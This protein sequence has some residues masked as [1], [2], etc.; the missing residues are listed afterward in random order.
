MVY[1][2]A[3][4]ILPIIILIICLTNWLAKIVQYLSVKSWIKSFFR[5]FT[6]KIIN[7]NE[8]IEFTAEVYNQSY[9]LVTNQM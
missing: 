1:E 8:P 9:E 5:V 2:M 7:E 4:E 6:K 3:Y